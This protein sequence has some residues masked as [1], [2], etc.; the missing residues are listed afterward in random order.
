MQSTLQAGGINATIA[1][2]G[3]AKKE[4]QLDHLASF[5][6]IEPLLEAMSD[7]IIVDGAGLH[8]CN[9]EIASK[10]RG[11]LQLFKCHDRELA[12]V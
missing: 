2:I 9:A 5:S 6:R 11:L 4:C 12:I 7:V 8:P 3:N 1:T 10:A